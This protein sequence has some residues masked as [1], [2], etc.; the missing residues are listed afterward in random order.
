MFWVPVVDK[1]ESFLRLVTSALNS[2][3]LHFA[4]LEKLADKAAFMAKAMPA[5]LLFCR[6]F[7]RVIAERRTK[8][9][10]RASKHRDWVAL[11]PYLREDLAEWLKNLDSYM[12][13]GP[14]L[15]PQ[16][17]LL[18]VETD[19]SSRAWGGVVLAPEVAPFKCG[20]I[21]GPEELPLPIN[22]KEM[23]GVHRT[24]LALIHTKGREAVAGRRF[25]FYVDNLAAIANFANLG[26][27]SPELLTQ[28][29]KQLFFLQ[30]DDEFSVSF[31]WWST[32]DN[33]TADALSRPDIADDWCL[34]PAA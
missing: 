11:A 19:A 25:D 18:R 16:H 5:A 4:T 31:Q 6:S 26:G 9:W 27:P 14:W 22:T 28:V 7:Y 30:H 1:K 32:H 15:A 33:V 24:L 3:G 17:S 21:F 8:H 29:A 2:D 10:T 12:N 34:H 20:A 23:L 13:G